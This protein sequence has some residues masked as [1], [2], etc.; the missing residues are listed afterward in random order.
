MAD[1]PGTRL[2][3]LLALLACLATLSG[4]GEEAPIRIG[5]VG[6]LSGRGA[7][8]GESS[9][10]AVQLAIEARNAQ[11]GIDGRAI[12]LLVRDD[13]TSAEGGA[14]AARELADADVDLVIG[15]N[16][17]AVASGIVPVI[18][19]RQLLTISP[20]VSALAFAGVDDMFLRINWTTR[21]NARTYAQWQ[22]EAQARRRL[23][24]A[25]D[26]NNAVFSRSWADEFA[27]AASEFGGEI[28]AEVGLDGNQPTGFSDVASALL[29]PAPDAV[30][31]IANAVDVAR[32][33][34]QL[35]KTDPTVPLVAAEWAG[36]E[37][38][39]ALGGRAIEG[40]ELVQAY[41]RQSQAPGYLQFRQAYVARFRDEPGYASI[42]AYDAATVALEGLLRREGRETLKQTIARIATFQGLQQPVRFD[43]FGDAERKAFF[44][45]VRDGRFI[46]E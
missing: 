46:R 7:D 40:L 14:Q 42:A 36:S 38:L 16:I 2:P 35:R 5:F 11:G 30:I 39:I 1:M 4:C 23:A 44:V 43:P 33:A 10:K 29:L 31:M 21:D 9:R 26:T 13:R 37:Q 41:D 32:L 34:Q 25:Y 45:R 20:T 12:E 18:N 3:R 8:I 19:E 22:V 28:V 24:L 6:S 27:R 15:P 17:S